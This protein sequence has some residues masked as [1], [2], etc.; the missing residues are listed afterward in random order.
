MISKKDDG[1]YISSWHKVFSTSSCRPSSVSGFMT[2]WDIVLKKEHNLMRVSRT[3][4][5]KTFMMATGR[6]CVIIT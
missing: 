1:K 5:G 6:I 4:L 2:F 3:G